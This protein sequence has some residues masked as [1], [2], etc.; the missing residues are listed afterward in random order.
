[1]LFFCFNCENLLRNV[2]FF[3]QYY[4]LASL[5]DPFLIGSIV[6]REAN[7]PRFSPFVDDQYCITLPGDFHSIYKMQTVWIYL[8]ESRP[9]FAMINIVPRPGGFQSNG[10]H[11]AVIQQVISKRGRI[12]AGI[13]KGSLREAFNFIT[14]GKKDDIFK[15]KKY[16]LFLL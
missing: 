2:H 16:A 6:K 1:M 11:Q 3:Y 8:A 5:S 7:P 10:N 4:E 15:R 13:S 14:S 12:S 9:S